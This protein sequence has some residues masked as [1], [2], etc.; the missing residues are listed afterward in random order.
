MRAG[1]LL[2]PA[3]EAPVITYLLDSAAVKIQLLFYVANPCNFL[4]PKEGRFLRFN[5]DRG[6][7]VFCGGFPE[8]KE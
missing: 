2:V 8:R 1:F 5:G 4:F 6:D 3:A 7:R